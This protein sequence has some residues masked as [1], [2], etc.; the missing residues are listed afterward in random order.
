[1]CNIYSNHSLSLNIT[2]LRDTYLLKKPIH[3]IH[4]RA[5]EIPMSGGLQ[6]ASYTEELASYFEEN[7]EIVLYRCHEE[8]IEKAKFYLN[9][10][11]EKLIQNMKMS[12][13]KRAESEHTWSKRLQNI[14]LELGIS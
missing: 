14:T 2:E 5:F 9:S 8:M 10:K 7:R 13:R 6:F 11:N 12:A 4:L 1:M 3:K